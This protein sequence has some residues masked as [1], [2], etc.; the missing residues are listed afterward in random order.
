MGRLLRPLIALGVVGAALAVAGARLHARESAPLLLAGPHP[1]ATAGAQLGAYD[2]GKLKILEPTLYHVELSYVEPDRI[3]YER[4]YRSGLEAVERRVPG[5]R[6]T[7]NADAGRVSLEIGDLSTVLEVDRVGSS[8]ELQVELRRVASLLQQHLGPDDVPVDPGQDPHSEIEYAL[9]NG[10]LDTLDPHSMLLPPEDASEMDVENQGEFGGLGVTIVERDGALLVESTLTGTPAERAGVL[11]HDRITRIAGQSTM[12]MSL[13]EAV[14][15]LRGPVGAPIGI[16]IMRAGFDEP[17]TFSIQ[18]ELIKL[19]EV[20]GTLLE[21][22]VGVVRIQTFHRN[23]ESELHATLARL[24]RESSSGRLAGLILDLRDNPGGYLNQAVAVSDTFL[25]Q[26]EIVS[27]VDGAGRRQ[28]VKHA[29]RTARTEEPY[30]MV[31][32]LNASSASASEIVAGALRNNERAVI[33]GERS[34]GK[35]SVQDLHQLYDT[36]KLKLTISQY[37]TPGDKSIQTVGIPADVELLPVR[38]DA[39]DE[40]AGDAAGPA[41]RVYWRERVR[42]EADLDQRLDRS[43]RSLDL[44]GETAYSFHYLDRGGPSGNRP[45]DTS[46]YPTAFA[47]ELLLAAGSARRPDT[48]AKAGRLVDQHARRGD[49]DIVK[50]FGEVGIDWTDGVSR[51]DGPFP[52]EASLDLGPDGFI[53]A[54][55]RE[56]VTLTL[57]N[58]SDR[59]LYRVGAL[60]LEHDVLAGREFLFGKLEP[61]ASRS[62]DVWVNLVDGYPDHEGDVLLSVRDGES[63]PLGETRVPVH[64]RGRSLPSLTWQAGFVEVE[65]DQDG[66]AEVG[67]VIGIDLRVTNH[68]PGTSAAAFARLKHRAG[69]ALD[70]MD[71]MVEPGDLRTADGKSCAKLD[72]KAGCQRRMLA[73]ERWNGRLTVKLKEQAEPT[74]NLDLLVGDD[75]AYDHASVV[76]AGLHEHFAQ[77]QRLEIPA[78]Q[79]LGSLSESVPPSVEITR[80]PSPTSTA[81]R[82]TLSGRVTDD[83]GIRHVMVFAGGDKLFYEGERGGVRSVPFTADIPLKPGHNVITVVAEDDDGYTRTASVVTIGPP[84]EVARSE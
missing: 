49:A 70:I 65:G 58:T 7:R 26:G 73:G 38:V 28:D 21:G 82:V 71:G 61:G 84:S 33:V 39:P 32:L 20:A 2:L 78:D 64:I 79:P 18:R 57:R 3:D 60:A 16:E 10:V 19:N 27:T 1:D 37:L 23:V 46:D 12:N 63:S 77:K 51:H 42:R 75:E 52:V 5:F 25:D 54:G 69:R 62:F 31:V 9:V 59:T 68:G 50:A 72:R 56:K 66:V 47:R 24:R 4:M 35:G 15:L 13:D 17:R 41:A 45:L 81:D 22:D 80:R 11:A 34:F 8:R 36:S 83:V 76:A 55:V 30:P 67:E 74:W 40:A 6:F 43:V 48:L 29:R 44:S 14:Q 53:D